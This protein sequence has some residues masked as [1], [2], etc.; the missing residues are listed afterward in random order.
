MA[1]CCWER[2]GVRCG[3]ITAG[4][5]LGWALTCRFWLIVEIDCGNRDRA[6]WLSGFGSKLCKSALSAA[7]LT[8]E[9]LAHPNAAGARLHQPDST[10]AGFQVLL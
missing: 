6:A 2:L 5:E 9:Q 7:R 3:R 1:E 8:C 4:T 10:S